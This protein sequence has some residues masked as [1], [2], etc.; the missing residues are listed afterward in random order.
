MADVDLE[1]LME[2]LEGRFFGK[3]R[4]K[5][6]ANED[7]LKRGSV[8]VLVPAVM[9]RETLWALPCAPYAGPQLGFF[10]IPPVGGSVW[11]EFEGGR[12][13]HPIWVG[14]IWEDGEIDAPDSSPDIVFLRTPG[15]VIRIEASGTLEIET[16]GGA[17]ITMTGTEITLEA[18]SIKH[19]ANGGATALSASG[20]DAMNGAFKVV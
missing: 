1:R 13:D 20:F 10:A 3:Y 14:A 4:G 5:V 18:P 19:S 8:E 7:P 12:R 2:E 15:A 6:V 9:G 16:E 11:V 17:K